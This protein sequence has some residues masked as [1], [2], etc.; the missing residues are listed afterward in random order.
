MDRT[1]ITIPSPPTTTHA[2]DTF[3]TPPPSPTNPHNDDTFHT[4]PSTPPSTPYFRLDSSWF[5]A[6]LL[7]QAQP[8]STW[9]NNP[10]P[11]TCPACPLNFVTDVPHNQGRYLHNGEEAATVD[12]FFGSNNL[13]PKLWEASA[14]W[15]RGEA[16]DL[17]KLLIEGFV[18]H[19]VK[20]VEDGVGGWRGA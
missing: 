10:S 14:R 20:V 3:H 15:V 5:A 1:F 12:E 19:H 9:L 18:R 16:D 11:C 13:P 6:R 7:C 4:P 17:D 2:P 8:L